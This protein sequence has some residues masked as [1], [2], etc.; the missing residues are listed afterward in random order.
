M[1]VEISAA[2]YTHAVHLALRG[3]F[4][5]DD[6]AICQLYRK[7]HYADEEDNYNCDDYYFF[8]VVLHTSC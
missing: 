3:P 8:H 6:I 7:L 4:N 1:I 2:R 5:C